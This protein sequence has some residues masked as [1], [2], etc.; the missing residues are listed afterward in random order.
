[1][2]LLPPLASYKIMAYTGS[3]TAD[4]I[5]QDVVNTIVRTYAPDRVI[6]FGSYAWG[7]PNIDSDIDLCVVKRSKKNR[8]QR[9]LELRKK[10]YPPP[11]AIDLLVLT[12]EE[13]KHRLDIN[14]F[15]ISEI[16]TKGKKIYESERLSK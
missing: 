4:D 13:I 1:M 15:F 14:D 8:R 12:P 5:I 16:M 3:M 2:L 6:L 7:K 9:E 11:A 10:L